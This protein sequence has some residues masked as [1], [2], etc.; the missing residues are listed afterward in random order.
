MS[1][2]AS[3]R[4]ENLDADLPVSPEDVVIQR[5]LRKGRALSTEE[6][7][8]FLDSLAATAPR[9]ASHPRLPLGFEPFELP[10]G[11]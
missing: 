9:Q 5:R 7:V 3:R 10:R 2:G 1:S 8:R 6:N 4:L 11:S